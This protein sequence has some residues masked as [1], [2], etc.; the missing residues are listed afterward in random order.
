MSDANIKITEGTVLHKPRESESFD[1][2]HHRAEFRGG[3]INSAHHKVE[4]AAE[5]I[6]GGRKKA[7]DE[8][9]KQESGELDC[10]DNLWCRTRSWP[11]GE[12]RGQ[13][14]AEERVSEFVG[15]YIGRPR[16][17]LLRTWEKIMA[18]EEG[19]VEN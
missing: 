11:N 9:N 12:P 6:S 13:G 5:D 16:A 2:V 17:N 14:R 18:D 4:T 8:A 1:S 10:W 19:K 15:H 3:K 7:R